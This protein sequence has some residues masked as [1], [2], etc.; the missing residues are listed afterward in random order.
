MI[1]TN[2]VRLGGMF[3]EDILTDEILNSPEFIPLAES[4]TQL[5][6]KKKG[7]EYSSFN[8]SQLNIFNMAVLEN[9]RAKCC[10]YMSVYILNE[11]KKVDKADIK[12]EKY[13]TV[14]DWKNE[15][16]AHLMK[17]NNYLDSVSNTSSNDSGEAYCVV[18][19]WGE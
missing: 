8:E 6:L 11:A 5:L 14:Q 3:D 9:V 19:K 12:Y 7:V 4:E 17:S 16:Q 15:A 18:V 2:D 13:A 10:S 1:N